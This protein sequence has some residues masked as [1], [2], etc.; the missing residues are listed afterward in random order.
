[1]PGSNDAQSELD[2][3]ACAVRQAGNELR[4]EKRAAALPALGQ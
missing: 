2:R 4:D 3:L 1:M